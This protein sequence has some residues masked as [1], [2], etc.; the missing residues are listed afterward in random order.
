MSRL[1]MDVYSIERIAPL[2]LRARNTLDKLGYFNVHITL[3]D[4]SQGLKKNAPFD[5]IIVTA[6]AP[7]IPERL[8]EQLKPDGRLIIPIGS[9]SSQDLKC[10]VNSEKGAREESLGGCRFVKLIGEE[11]WSK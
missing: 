1:C 5:G 3:G 6:G 4:G 9:Q 8:I 11:G 2:A 10:I 7:H